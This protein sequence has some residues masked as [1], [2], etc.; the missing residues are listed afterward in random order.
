MPDKL[1]PTITQKP[2]TAMNPMDKC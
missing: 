2:T 1:C